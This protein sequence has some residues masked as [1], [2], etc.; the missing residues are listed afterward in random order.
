MKVTREEPQGA[1]PPDLT[2]SPNGTGPKLATSKKLLFSALTCLGFFAILELVLW[3]AGVPTQ[4]EQED[5]FRGFSGLVKVFQREGPN[6]RTRPGIRGGTF[7]D[8]SFLAAKPANGLRLFCLGGSSSFGF[9]WGA[10]A[11]F[12]S[13]V[14]EALAAT[15]PERQ[16]EAVNASGVSYA[17]HR[18]N[19]VADELLDYQP[20][21]FIVYEGHNEFIEPAFFDALKHRG[22]LRTGFEYALSYSRVYSGMRF[23]TGRLRNS[24][25]PPASGFETRVMRDQ[26]HVYAPAEKEA[27]VA[28]FRWRLE[29]LVRRARAADVKVVLATVP[30]NL[31]QWRPEASTGVASLAEHDRQQRSELFTAGGRLLKS[32][33]FEPAAVALEQAARLAP[34][35]AETRFLLGQAYEGLG[36]FDD[37]RGAYQ[38]A[39]DEDASPIRRLSGINVAIREIARQQGVLLVDVDRLF[40]QQSEHGLV[41][42]NL[43]EDYVHP[44]RQGHELIAWHLWEA[45]EQAGWFN[46][47]S[48]ARQAVFDRILAQRRPQTPAQ[49]AVWFYNQGVVLEKQDQVDAAIKRYR[50][51]LELSPGYS[52]ALLNLGKLLADTGQ[53]AEAVNHYQEALRI[54]PGYADAHNNLGAALASLGR[55]DDAVAHYQEALRIRPDFAGAHLNLGVALANRGQVDEAMTHYQQALE[56]NPDQADAHNNLGVALDGRG[57]VDEAMAHY[58]K[59]LEIKPDHADAHNNLGLDLANRGRADEAIAHYQQALEIKPNYAEAHLNLGMALAGRGQ[60]DEAIA[61]YQQA[62]KIKPDFANAHFNLGV[63]LAGRRQL[64]EAVAHYQQAL[65]IKPDYA[66][67]HLNLGAALAGRGQAAEAITHYQQ[68]LKIQPDFA[69]AHFNLAV[70][71][72]GRGQADEAIAHYQ[73]ALKTKPDFVEAHLNLGNA[74]AGHGQVDEAIAHFQK[75]LGLVSAR[76]D[77]TLADVIRARLS[78]L[79]SGTPAGQAQ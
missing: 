6:Y 20:D 77:K 10:E 62:L 25:H 7:N 21:V 17:M 63:A 58:Q 22:T 66:A 71:L 68:A 69:N 30:C 12:T 13:I 61:D 38:R 34:H 16:V 5:P 18:L 19:L 48:D 37:A 53:F 3:A 45:M 52:N 14:G 50:E 60:I 46:G 9:P 70:A 8:Q 72:A 73:M 24:L 39:C 35:H 32:G 76:N 41:G 29:R 47:K 36:R 26:T 74:L 67:A 28:E 33:R 31:R 11:A 51:A 79:Q 4:I 75:A 59:A 56:I 2:G 78:R 57:R 23:A 40:E 42:F 43:I 54:R 15:H 27:I 49:N 55:L 64:D 65:A 1:T 44:T